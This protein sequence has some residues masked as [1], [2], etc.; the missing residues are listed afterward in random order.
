MPRRARNLRDP[1]PNIGVKIRTTALSVKVEAVDGLV[2]SEISISTD[3]ENPAAIELVDTV[4]L[5]IAGNVIELDTRAAE[6]AYSAKNN[7]GGGVMIGNGGV[8]NNMFVGR[9]VHVGGNVY[10]AAN[11]V[12]NVTM[13]GGRV[14]Q[15]DVVVSDGQVISSGG[16]NGPAITITARVPSGTQAGFAS[17]SGDITATGVLGTLQARTTSGDVDAQTVADVDVTTA[18]GDVDIETADAVGISTASGDTKIETVRMAAVQS[19]SG[20]ISIGA[21]TGVATIQSAS[22]NVRIT[23]PSTAS[24]GVMTASGNIRL[25]GGM[26]ETQIQ[27]FSGKIR[28]EG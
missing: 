21:L 5:A 27:T 13:A 15:G 4:H 7:P 6:A 19:A 18:S 9:N 28:R 2:Y 25:N 16:I 12:G 24:V 11:V 14:Y 10:Q 8:Q 23:G 20:D 17:N 1:R 26:H 3:D 22:G